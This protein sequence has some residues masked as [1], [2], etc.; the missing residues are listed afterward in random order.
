MKSL[1]VLI[2]TLALG[3]GCSIYAAPA[4][5]QTFLRSFHQGAAGACHASAAISRSYNDELGM[6]R[7]ETGYLNTNSNNLARYQ[8]IT[9]V[10]NP[11]ADLYAVNTPDDVKNV[12]PE[13]QL[14]ARNTKSNIDV[15]LTCVLYG[16]FVNS[17]TTIQRQRSVVLPANGTQRSIVWNEENYESY[18]PT[19]LSIVCDVP[20]GIEL[21]DWITLYI[22]SNVE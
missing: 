5:A 10:C 4:S 11:I 18:Y 17:A 3:F 2:T 12:V 1:H 19:P 16:G 6:S 21:N 7:S 8:D 15:T 9:V 14:F 20:A 13:V 22:E